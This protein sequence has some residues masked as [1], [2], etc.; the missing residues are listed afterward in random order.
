MQLR[1]HRSV[2]SPCS[3]YDRGPKQYLPSVAAPA[4]WPCST[5]VYHRNGARKNNDTI[6]APFLLRRRRVLRELKAAG[7]DL[8]GLLA[9]LRQLISELIII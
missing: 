5:A 4:A 1:R 3:S 2:T 8:Q 6:A 9:R 7:I